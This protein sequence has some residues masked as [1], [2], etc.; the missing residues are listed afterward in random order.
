LEKYDL[1][2]LTKSPA[3]Y[4]RVLAFNSNGKSILKKIK[5]NSDIEIITKM[6]KKNLNEHLEIDILGTKAYSLL[7]NK[8]NPMDDYL[9]SPIII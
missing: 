2:K 9:K 4:A 6:P 3:P 8:I 5:D 1:F 7:N